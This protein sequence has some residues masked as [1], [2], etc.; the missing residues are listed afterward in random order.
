MREV[1]LP[2]GSGGAAVSDSYMHAWC[3]M[4]LPNTRLL[5]SSIMT[6]FIKATPYNLILK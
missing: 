5:S 2:N 4:Q 6:L 3:T 1:A